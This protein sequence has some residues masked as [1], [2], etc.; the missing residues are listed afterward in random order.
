MINS[1]LVQRVSRGNKLSDRWKRE[2]EKNL[3]DAIAKF[4]RGKEGDF[5]QALMIADN[6]T[7]TIMRNYLVFKCTENPPFAYPSLLERICKKTQVCSEDIET[8]ETFRL[9][10]DGLYHQNIKQLDKG[11][12]GTTVGL[13]LEK[14]L[15]RRLL[16][17]SVQIV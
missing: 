10:R 4:K 9:I 16:E 12:K 1:Q 15:L 8:V 3:R 14:K 5:K 7:E 6:V 17:S 13:T 11:L 2:P